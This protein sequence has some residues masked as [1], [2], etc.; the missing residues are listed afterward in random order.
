MHS[1]DDGPGRQMA[2]LVR[3]LRFLL[4]QPRQITST[5]RS[6]STTLSVRWRASLGLVAAVHSVNPTIAAGRC[7]RSSSKQ[8]T[9]TKSSTSFARAV[10]W[11]FPSTSWTVASPCTVAEYRPSVRGR[12]ITP[13]V[14]GG[15]KADY[16][17]QHKLFGV[18]CRRR[19]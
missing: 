5:L 18:R 16:A 10:N 2:L 15:P 17:E 4:F 14:E 6:T 1:R 8:L 19:Q 13:N 7:K 3:V 12:G 11:M 9:T